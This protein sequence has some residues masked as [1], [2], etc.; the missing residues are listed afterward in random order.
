MA[1]GPLTASSSA[2]VWITFSGSSPKKPHGHA[3]VYPSASHALQIEEVLWV[4]G[5]R[6]RA[7]RCVVLSPLPVGMPLVILQDDLTDDL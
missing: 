6:L 2:T 1:P 5:K 7:L 3:A 4:G